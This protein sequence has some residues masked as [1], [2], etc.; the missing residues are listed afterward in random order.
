MTRK[1]SYP[2]L[3][4]WLREQQ[5]AQRSIDEATE[6]AA[7]WLE[8]ARLAQRAGNQALVDAA[9]EKMTEI[10]SAHARA[11]TRLQEAK[12]ALATLRAEPQ[13]IDDKEAQFAQELLLSFE[14]M[15]IDPDETALEDA[16]AHEAV[17]QRIQEIKRDADLDDDVDPLEL[18]KA[19]MR[20]PDDA[21]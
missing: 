5:D 14:L 7:R 2:E 9:K 19:R 20:A 6:E 15:G 21:T 1:S 8:R 11:N 3:A 4:H 13:K 17:K 18:L 16:L 10:R 12:N